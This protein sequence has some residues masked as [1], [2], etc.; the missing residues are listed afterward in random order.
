MKLGPCLFRLRHLVTARSSSI[1]PPLGHALHSSAPSASK[2]D[3]TKPKWYDPWSSAHVG[4]EKRLIELGRA[5]FETAGKR[6]KASFVAA[7]RRYD[8]IQKIQRRGHVEFI[9]AALAQ[10]ND[11]GVHRDIAAYKLLLRLFPVGKMVPKSAWQV[12]MMH[13]PKQQDCCIELLE[14]MEV[15]GTLTRILARLRNFSFIIFY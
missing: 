6:N 12:D 2:E 15:N 8:H 9:R 4:D 5:K 3:D 13:Y 11:C 10:M 1:F 14:Q 7:V